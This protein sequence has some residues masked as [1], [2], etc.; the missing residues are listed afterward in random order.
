MQGPFEA[1]Y[2]NGQMS[3]VGN[4]KNSLKDG[5]FEFYSENGDLKETITFENGKRI[6][7]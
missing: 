6:Q 3:I 5:V 1:Y 7:Q 4:Y 2:P